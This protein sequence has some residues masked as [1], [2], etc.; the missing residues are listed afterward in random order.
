MSKQSAPVRLPN[1]KRT[2]TA[3]HGAIS[4]VEHAARPRLHSVKEGLSWLVAL[5]A[6]AT[7]AYRSFQSAREAGNDAAGSAEAEVESELLRHGLEEANASRIAA[8]SGQAPVA[9]A[10]AVLTA[11][12]GTG[13]ASTPSVA[14]PKV[15]GGF[16]SLAKE[17]YARFTNDQGPTQAAAL[18]FYGML[19]LVPIL[20]FALAALGFVIKSPEQAA[21]YVHD[22]VTHMLPGQAA[23]KAADQFIQQTNI[24]ASAQGLMRNKWW[25]VLIGLVSLL[26]SAVSLL[27]SAAEAMDAAWET[28]ETR[29]FVKLR[30]VAITVFF[31]AGLLF[32]LSLL[33]SSG[34]DFIQRLH[35]PWLGLPKHPPF[36]VATLM[37]VGFEVLAWLIDIGMFVLI[38]R[39]LP[40]VPVSWKAAATGGAIAGLLWEIFKKAFTV[41]LAHFGNFNKLYGA[42]GGVILL[43]TWINYSCM[44]LLIGAII[45]KMYH[46]HKEEGGV[47]R[48]A[49]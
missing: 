37:Q 42:L 3:V 10:K 39:F 38:Y 24:V 34:P 15:D 14:A 18:S 28:K 9:P 27:V 25:A 45:C 33:P 1:R 13:T 6:G 43:V 47:A 22:V 35:I 2:R 7:V 16:M 32:A 29:S 12:P 17:L 20:M 49:T 46:E 26:W 8:Q 31:G 30:L 21:G 41:Y 19:S 4:E 23:S 44:V 48:K 5:S 40:N 11:L 36:I